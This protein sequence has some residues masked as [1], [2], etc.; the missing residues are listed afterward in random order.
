[1]SLNN[2]PQTNTLDES[3]DVGEGISTTRAALMNLFRDSR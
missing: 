1:M 3:N 2:V